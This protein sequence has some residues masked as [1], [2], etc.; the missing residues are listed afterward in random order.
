MP[1]A[2]ELTEA[3]QK[4][5][6]IPWNQ[7]TEITPEAAALVQEHIARM[8][9][10]MEFA[11]ANKGLTP[12]EAYAE[13]QSAG[14]DAPGYDTFMD[15]LF[16]DVEFHG[17]RFREHLILAIASYFFW[18]EDRD[19]GHLANPWEPM[20]EL[21]RKGYTSSFDEDTNAQSM[22]VVLSYQGGLES[23]KLI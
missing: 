15:M 16:D 11:Q 7:A 5:N 22:N 14:Y 3:I 23:Y 9:K 21:Y 1:S 12:T 2:G 13:A 20:L 19:L 18:T 10:V 4:L 6:E 17:A 8:R